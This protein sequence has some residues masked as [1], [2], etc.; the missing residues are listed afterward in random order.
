MRG[1]T[2]RLGGEQSGSGRGFLSQ[3]SSRTVRLGRV[4]PQAP[5]HRTIFCNDRDANL[6]VKFKVLSSPL[7]VHL[8]FAFFYCLCFLFTDLLKLI[9]VIP[10]V[11][12][13]LIFHVDDIFKRLYSTVCPLPLLRP[14]LFVYSAF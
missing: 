4:Q 7:S 10:F 6:P 11:F 2:A 9:Y 3:A 8:A 5:G 12:V 13:Y 1:S 14:F